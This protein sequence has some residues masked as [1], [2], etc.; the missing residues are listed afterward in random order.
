M[1]IHRALAIL[2]ALSLLAATSVF[3]QNVDQ[4]MDDDAEENGCVSNRQIYPEGAE[5][6]Q[7]GTSVRCQAGAWG[8]IGV[9]KERPG[10][11]PVSQ[12]GDTVD[13]QDPDTVDAED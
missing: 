5:L 7:E 9:C 13:T 8:A 11:A 6:C 10:Q 12:G 1:S 2:G 3:A 4:D